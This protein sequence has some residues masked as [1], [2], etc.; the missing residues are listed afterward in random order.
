[1][2]E[3]LIEYIRPQTTEEAIS[4]HPTGEEWELQ[5]PVNN[6]QLDI[7]GIEARVHGWAL[8]RW[9]GEVR[10]IYAEDLYYES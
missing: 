8:F 2:S 3:T 10:V 6:E 5:H 9:M 4:R 1:M 7:L